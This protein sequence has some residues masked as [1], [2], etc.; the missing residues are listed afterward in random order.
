VPAAQAGPSYGHWGV[1]KLP[2]K[3]IAT[4]PVHQRV[5]KI[6][7]LLFP[8]RDLKLESGY[9][10]SFLYGDL[11]LPHYDCGPEYD[12]IT[13]IYIVNSMWKTVWGGETLFYDRKD[14]AVA[15]ATPRPGRLLLL[16]SRL[17][18]QAGIPNQSCPGSR[19][20]LAARYRGPRRTHSAARP[21]WVQDALI[22]M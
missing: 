3:T 6:L 9:L 14:N 17:K 8:G 11:A 18:H 13:A 4:Y 2:R 16:P 1:A 19:I 7:P 15:C 5:V 12:D 21:Q 10:N 20:T 22:Q